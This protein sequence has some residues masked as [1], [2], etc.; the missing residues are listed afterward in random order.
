MFRGVML[1]GSVVSASYASIQVAPD[2]VGSFMVA[3][4]VGVDNLIGVLLALFCVIGFVPLYARSYW[5]GTVFQ[6]FAGGAGALV[7]KVKKDRKVRWSLLGGL[8]TMALFIGIIVYLPESYKLY[9]GTIIGGIELVVILGFLLVSML[10]F[11]RMMLG[12]R[13]VLRA[14]I[15][16]STLS[17]PEIEYVLGKLRLEKSRLNYLRTIY[18]MVVK[19]VGDWTFGFPPSLNNDR[20]GTE[21][22]KPEARWLGID[23]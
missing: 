22:A 20:S 18:D 9:I 1:L 19:P 23:P 21:L 2:Y 6:A 8:A 7:Q 13:A 14:H 16:R 4:P 3:R 11:L 5:S 10:T 15:V 12:D 17:R